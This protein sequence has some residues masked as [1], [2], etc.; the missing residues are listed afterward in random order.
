MTSALLIGTLAAAAASLMALGVL[1]PWFRRL[2][3]IDVPVGRSLHTAPVVRGAGLALIP[4][5]VTG[6]AVTEVVLARTGGG[7]SVTFSSTLYV[8]LAVVAVVAFGAIGLSDDFFSHGVVSRLSIQLAAGVLAAGALITSLGAWWGWLA[9]VAVALVASVNITNFMDGANGLL[10][11]HGLVAAGWFCLLATTRDMPG[12]AALSAAVGGSLLAVAP[13][14]FRGRAFL[15]DVGSYALGAVWA[16]LGS[17]FLLAGL[18]AETVL[19][20][21]AVFLADFVYTLQLRLRAG[22]RW[23]QPHKLHVYQRLVSAGWPHLASSGLVAGLTAACC[24]LALPAFL[25]ADLMARLACG[26]LTLGLVAAYLRLPVLVG[27]PVPWHGGGPRGAH[28]G[29]TAL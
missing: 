23:Y 1:L 14:N 26:L 15:G 21:A 28:T 27:A 8:V 16:V 11:L 20:P 22:D 3:V 12:L 5:M 4:G 10:I 7:G 29:R 17:M 24:L 9:P 18:P 2:G 13:V 6:A 19:A 25:G